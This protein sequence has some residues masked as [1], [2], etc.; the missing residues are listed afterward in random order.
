[1]RAIVIMLIAVSL[2]GCKGNS[3]KSQEP[4]T[5]AEQ[6]ITLSFSAP[7]VGDEYAD[8]TLPDATGKQV[9]LSKIASSDNTRYILLDFWASWCGP[10]MREMPHLSEAYAKYHAKGFQI[11]AVSLDS[12]TEAWQQAIEKNN[13]KWIN[14]FANANS[15]R[16]YEWLSSIPTNMLIDCATGK[17]VARNL[18]GKALA[19]TLAEL[20]K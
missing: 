9:T 10:C 4:A 15:P 13:A 2:C 1:M 6:N 19:T 5:T 12:D 8:I 7:A 14:L 17:I 11:Y 18:R 20:L 3:T 16:G